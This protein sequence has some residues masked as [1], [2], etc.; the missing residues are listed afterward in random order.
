MFVVASVQYRLL[1]NFYNT[2]ISLQVFAY[3]FFFF[4]LTVVFFKFEGVTNQKSE[5]ITLAIRQVAF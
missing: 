4:P 1:Q 2:A 3:G 5:I